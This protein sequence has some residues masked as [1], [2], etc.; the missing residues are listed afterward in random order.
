[1]TDQTTGQVAGVDL[2]TS[3]AGLDLPHPVMSAS[4]CAGTG[5]ELA[6]FYDVADLAAFVTRSITLDPD[7]GHPPPRMVET[8]SGMLSA[9]GLQGPGVQGFLASELPWLAQRRTRTIVSIAGSTLGEYAELVR[10]LAAG[11]GVAGIEVNL[12]HG[13]FEGV[14]RLLAGDPY[15]AA[16]VI[17]VV[18]RDSPP[19]VP[20]FAKLVPDGQGVVAVA[21]AVVDAG[22]DGV[23]LIS[24]PLGMAIDPG[25][26]RPALG[27]T[28]GGLS[29][30]AVRP[31]ALRCVWEVHAAMPDLAIVGVG[32]VRSGLDALELVLAGASAVQVGSVTFADPSACT[33]V[34]RE[35]A[36]ELASRSIARV[37]DVVGRAHRLEGQQL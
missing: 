22:A 8:P 19:G 3:L 12:S 6:A 26:L 37:A 30:P 28:T 25:T 35:L 16:R 13:G 18:R 31:L 14:G 24:S 36:E 17:S 1:M 21:R 15:Q 32:G 20:V 10:R 9:V 11:P 33:R 2:S 27:G 4:G 34:L 23:V 5:K 29:G 7:A